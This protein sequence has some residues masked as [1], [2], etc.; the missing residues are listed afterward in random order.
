MLRIL[1]LLLLAV[2]QLTAIELEIR[3]PLLEKQ[4]SQQ[5]FS[6]DG[7]RY[8]RGNPK[9]RCNFAYLANPHFGSREDKLLI[10]AR[11]TGR[12][13]VDILGKCVGFGDSFDF[14]VLAGLTTKDG[15]LLLTQPKVTL[16]GKDSF[17]A[18]KVRQALEG[19]IAEAVK[20][21]IREEIRK[22]LAAA[23]QSSP[24]RIRIGKLE[25]R[26]ISIQRESLLVDVDTRFEVE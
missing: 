11:F 3:F 21:P 14:E 13:S 20:Y 12:S 25:I 15:T 16:L 22:L 1:P 19:S 18:R 9:S 4:L 23:S 2:G 7:K 10:R 24:Y 8:V 5:L 6:Q 26:G 17:Y